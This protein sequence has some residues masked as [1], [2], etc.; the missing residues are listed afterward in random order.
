MDGAF[1]E[2][3]A[4]EL[5]RARGFIRGFKA[6]KHLTK[7]AKCLNLLGDPKGNRTPVFGVRGRSGAYFT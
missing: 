5:E 1:K 3:W 2:V 7:N 6:K 4:K